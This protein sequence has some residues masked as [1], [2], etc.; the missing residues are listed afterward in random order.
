V[1]LTEITITNVLPTGT[2][3]AAT[4]TASPEAVF[5]PGKVATI[6]GVTIGQRVMAL[7]VPNTF[8]PESTPW[9][10]ARIEMAA[11]NVD[12]VR[13]MAHLPIAERVRQALREGGVWTLASLYAHLF[14]NDMRS[15]GLRD[16][17]AVS[18]ALRSMFASG[19]CAKFQLWRS[20]DQSKP[21]REWFTCHPER[22]DVDE[23]VEE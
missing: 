1:K 16:Y 21:S 8:K 11:A 3:F 4:V 12:P 23:W 15:E 22:A 10:A 5:I 13:P 9:M 7:L 18:S 20:A 6:T 17:N 2:A 19:E 14:P